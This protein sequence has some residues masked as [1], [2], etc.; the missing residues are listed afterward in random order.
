LKSC[1]VL[2]DH[3]DDERDMTVF[4]NTPPDLQDQDQERCCALRPVFVLRS[5]VSDHI[6]EQQQ[7]DVQIRRQALPLR[8]RISL[9][10]WYVLLKF[11]MQSNLWCVELQT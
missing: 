9:T 2:Q 5:T 11:P 4:L 1:C 8:A 7:H 10:N 3:Y 6:S